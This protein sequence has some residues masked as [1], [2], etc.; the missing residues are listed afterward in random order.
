MFPAP[1]TVASVVP[2]LQAILPFALLAAAILILVVAGAAGF[3]LAKHFQSPQRTA[4]ATIGALTPERLKETP[5]LTKDRLADAA[6]QRLWSLTEPVLARQRQLVEQNGDLQRRYGQARALIDLMAEFNEVMQLSAVLDRLSAGLSRF[7]AGDG[8]AIWIRA[9]QGHF[10]LAVKVAENFPTTLN[11]SDRWVATVLAGEAGLVLPMWL[12]QEMPCMAAPLLDAQA[13]RIG[14]VALTSRR[15]PDY[16][17]E[18][19]AF[20]RTVVGHAAMAIQNATMYEFIDTL[21]RIDPL[22]GLHN[23]REFDRLLAQELTRA[24]QA[25]QPLS[26]IV[27]DIDHFKQINDQYGHQ[28]GDRALQQVARLIQLVPKRVTD[29]AF[30]TGGEEFAI[31][32][33]DTD[34]SGALMLSESLRSLTERARFFGTNQLVTVSLGVATFPADGQDP[35]TLMVAADRALYQAKAGGR[36]RVEAA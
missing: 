27:A 8:V 30:R 2:S 35:T 4:L 19:G 16:T 20:L 23:R 29:A 6:L 18:D 21:S 9:P 13:Q 3:R 32:M 1:R 25:G 34:K 10:E 7:F 36:N 24:Q 22:T 33:T 17:V 11:P 28:E 12:E 5:P 31:V 15:R 26:L 14:I